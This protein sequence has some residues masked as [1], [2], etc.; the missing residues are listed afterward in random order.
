[1]QH[2]QGSWLGPGLHRTTPQVQSGS[3]CGSQVFL[4]VHFR[5]RPVLS[6]LCTRSEPDCTP[7]LTD[8]AVLDSI[9]NYYSS[10]NR[11]LI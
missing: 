7:D 9:Q 1:M 11:I 4:E 5:V 6:M 2:Y 10:V 8:L 3:G